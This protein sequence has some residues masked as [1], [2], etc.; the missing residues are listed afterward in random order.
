MHAIPDEWKR[1]IILPFYK[2]KGS[3]QECK[4]YRGITLLSCPGKVFAHVILTRIKPLLLQRRRPEQSGFTPGRSTLD[5][6]LALNILQQTRT[7]FAQ[8]LW[9]AYVDLKAAF[10][11]V[12]RA[13]L[14][15]LLLSLGIPPK[16]VELIKC[17]YTDT[18]SAVRM[19]GSL[20]DFFPI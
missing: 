14:W 11:S 12:D 2:G 16:L 4:N 7:D 19:D 6:I 13:A 5:R 15:T 3:R 1:G 17:L 10:D 9:V 18:V 8:S 20:S